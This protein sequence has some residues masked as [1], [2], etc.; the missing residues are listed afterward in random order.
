MSKATLERPEVLEEYEYISD[1]DLPVSPN[2]NEGTFIYDAERRIRLK[3]LNP[4]TPRELI[5]DLTKQLVDICNNPDRYINNVIAAYKKKDRIPNIDFRTGL[6]VVNKPELIRNKVENTYDNDEELEPKLS[7]KEL[8]G[9][10]KI[11]IDSRKKTGI[12]SE[13]ISLLLDLANTNPQILLSTIDSWLLALKI[14]EVLEDIDR[15]ELVELYKKLELIVKIPQVKITESKGLTDS[16]L[17]VYKRS[18]NDSKIAA[19]IFLAKTQL[20]LSEMTDR[21]VTAINLIKSLE[22]TDSLLINQLI[23][24]AQ[25][26]KTQIE[27]LQQKLDSQNELVGKL[28]H[29]KGLNATLRQLPLM[30]QK[31]GISIEPK[32]LYTEATLVQSKELYPGF[33]EYLTK[34]PK[35]SKKIPNSFDKGKDLDLIPKQ[36][37]K[38]ESLEIPKKREGTIESTRRIMMSDVGKLLKDRWN[39]ARKSAKQNSKK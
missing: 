19:E 9:V 30:R 14:D 6:S 29:E 35:S 33:E 3:I 24:D 23:A 7:Q 37:T 15:A 16:N 32:S 28:N 27:S 8:E 26:L 1:I 4:N 13:K 21:Y 2:Y 20:K 18:A 5:S 39:S 36:K 25:E 22:S 34:P 11:L 31:F 12:G 38:T 10:Y 17:V